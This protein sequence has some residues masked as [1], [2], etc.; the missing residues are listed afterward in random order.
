MREVRQLVR[1]KHG[2]HLYGTS[3]PASDQDFKGVHLPSGRNIVLGRPED[4]ID[5]GVVAKEGTKNTSEAIDSQSFSLQK[6]LEM[7]A[8]GDTVAAEILFAPP[9]MWV[10]HDPLWLSIRAQAVCALNKQA[11][12]FVGYCQ[13]QA[14]KYGIKGSRMAAVKQ[15]I[16]LLSSL[17]VNQGLGMNATLGL[18]EVKLREF[19]K[20]HEHVEF[21]N[22]PNPNGS[23][24]WHIDCVDRK[25]S[26]NVTI[27]QAYDVYEKVWENY[28]ARARAAMTN[29]GIDWKAISHAVR[30]GRQALELLRD[31]TITFPRP[32]ADELLRIKLGQVPYNEVSPM[33]EAL[34]Q[35]VLET[36]STLPESTDMKWL[37]Q[38]V[39][40]YYFPQI[41]K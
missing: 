28:G 22:I 25:M 31:H 2:S 40:D 39:V 41:S 37:D 38:V 9:E 26:M 35:E 27:Q 13:R 12:G 14:A 20:T 10:E 6:F 24:N 7:L 23:D 1:V 5:K 16:D 33:L 21:V 30:V 15:L 32:D 17:G 29:E 11:K 3:T 8:K 4:V 34:V 36:D 19:A 18:Y